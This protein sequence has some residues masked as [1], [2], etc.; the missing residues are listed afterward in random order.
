MNLL[1][2]RREIGVLVHKTRRALPGRVGVGDW[3]NC[4]TDKESAYMIIDDEL[5]ILYFVLRDD[6]RLFKLATSSMCNFEG[7]A[8]SLSPVGTMFAARIV[9]D[10]EQSSDGRSYHTHR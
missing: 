7:R 4:V 8:K 9:R 5:S 3:G 1:G 10:D 6:G 2:E